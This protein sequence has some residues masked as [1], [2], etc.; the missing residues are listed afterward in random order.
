MNVAVLTAPRLKA[1][2]QLC[3]SNTERFRLLFGKHAAGGEE[4]G[5]QLKSAQL[6]GVGFSC[7]EHHTYTAGI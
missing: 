4:C 5:V 2:V 6:L 1:A 7:H 3:L